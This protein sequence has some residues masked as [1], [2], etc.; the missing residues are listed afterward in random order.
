MTLD[1]VK[2]VL[3]ALW[4]TQWTCHNAAENTVCAHGCCPKD[5]YYEDQKGHAASCKFVAL[6]ADLREQRDLIGDTRTPDLLETP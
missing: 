1:L 2:R 3:D 6:W 5:M 4:D